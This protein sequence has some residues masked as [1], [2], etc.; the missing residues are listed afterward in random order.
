MSFASLALSS[1]AEE[2]PHDGLGLPHSFY[3]KFE[4]FDIRDKKSHAKAYRR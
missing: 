2:A 3:G 1:F 4:V